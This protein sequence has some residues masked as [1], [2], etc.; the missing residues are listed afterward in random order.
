MCCRRLQYAFLIARFCLHSSSKNLKLLLLFSTA[1][2]RFLCVQLRDAK[3]A[4]CPISFSSS[5]S[6][7]IVDHRRP[8]DN[9]YFGYLRTMNIQSP[10]DCRQSVLSYKLTA[11]GSVNL[12]AKRRIQPASASPHFH[13]GTK[14]ILVGIHG[15]TSICY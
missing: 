9:A 15:I 2:C 10:D 7:I 5:P 4:L 14:I 3:S 12:P 13:C 11:M 1:R 8:H 6:Y